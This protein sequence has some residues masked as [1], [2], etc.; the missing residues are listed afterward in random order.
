[1]MQFESA[2]TQ[3]KGCTGIEAERLYFP[4]LSV[5]SIVSRGAVLTAALFL[6]ALQFRR[7]VFIQRLVQIERVIDLVAGFDL[8]L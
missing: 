5:V 3:A 6:A 7:W 2:Q 1:M 4:S 8:V